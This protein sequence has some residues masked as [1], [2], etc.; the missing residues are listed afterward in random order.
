MEKKSFS[1]LKL[2]FILAITS[3]L[4][5]S[6]YLYIEKCKLDTFYKSELLLKENKIEQY[7]QKLDL[8]KN[9]ITDLSN[10]NSD[11]FNFS[12]LA[13]YLLYNI[14]A[15]QNNLNEAIEY[16][17]DYFSFNRKDSTTLNIINSAI[18]DNTNV[19][20]YIEDN[21]LLTILKNYDGFQD[22]STL[23]LYNKIID[24]MSN[25]SKCASLI[26]TSLTVKAS[27]LDVMQYYGT[28]IDDYLSIRSSLEEMINNS[29]F[30]DSNS[31]LN[32]F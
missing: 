19:I 18:D 17:V 5:I 21:D 2:L 8:L 16:Y 28:L 22:T 4:S 13:F 14:T 27:N 30:Y 15:M 7:E 9:N 31:F 29:K 1:F 11:T 20:A 32:C 12:K 23:L 24:Y 10:S 3:L 6:I 25:F 26:Q